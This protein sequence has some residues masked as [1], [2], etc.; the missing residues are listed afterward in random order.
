MKI[1]ITNRY[2]YNH[3]V[4]TNYLDQECYGVQYPKSLYKKVKASVEKELKGI[5]IKEKELLGCIN[6]YL[7]NYYGF[8]MKT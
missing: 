7:E 1:K 4:W 2:R 6:Q 8:I 3:T 5:P